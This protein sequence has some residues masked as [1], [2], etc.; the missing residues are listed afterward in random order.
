MIPFE[1]VSAGIS[2]FFAEEILPKMGMGGNPF[3]AGM[4]E[5]IIKR[6]GPGFVE[7]MVR[8]MLASPWLKAGGIVD[9]QGNVDMDLLYQ[10]A[11]EQV[12]KTPECVIDLPYPLGKLTLRNADIEKLNQ[13]CRG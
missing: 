6:Q 12:S 13:L 4:A 5:I 10:A 2:R 8:P 11:K 3:L 9:D 1:K 7:G